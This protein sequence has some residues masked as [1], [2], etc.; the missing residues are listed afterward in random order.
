VLSKDLDLIPQSKMTGRQ[1]NLLYKDKR[2]YA[3]YLLNETEKKVMARR[4]HTR[5]TLVD[6][7]YEECAPGIGYNQK[8]SYLEDRIE[9]TNSYFKHL[10]DMN[11]KGAQME[12][13][14]K[15]LFKLNREIRRMEQ[16]GLIVKKVPLEYLNE[17]IHEEELE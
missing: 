2:T 13:W 8:N 9:A 17:Q 11:N 15:Q 16:E 1:M 3:E 10:D 12:T 14:K 4:A 6:T 5:N 7:I